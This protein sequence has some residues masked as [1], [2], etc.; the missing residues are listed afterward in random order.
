MRA[1]NELKVNRRTLITRLEQ[2]SQVSPKRPTRRHHALRRSQRRRRRRLYQQRHQPWPAAGRKRRRNT[3]NAKDEVC[4]SI[5][6]HPTPSPLYSSPPLL[7]N[8]PFSSSSREKG[9]KCHRQ[10]FLFSAPLPP[11]SSHQDVSPQLDTSRQKK[12]EE[13]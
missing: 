3:L 11:S 1:A 2:N 4:T 8:G 6:R 12:K 13:P 5:K 9:K 10:T 7:R